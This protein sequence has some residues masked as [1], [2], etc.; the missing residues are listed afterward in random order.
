M[1]DQDEICELEQSFFLRH[2]S[3][4][5][6]LTW[7]VFFMLLGIFHIL[8]TY[9]TRSPQ[10]HRWFSS[11]PLVGYPSGS[12]EKHLG[13]CQLVPDQYIRF[14]LTIRH[15]KLFPTDLRGAIVWFLMADDSTEDY[16]VSDLLRES[17]SRYDSKTISTAAALTA[18]FLRSN[19]AREAAIWKLANPTTVPQLRLLLSLLQRENQDIQDTFMPTIMGRGGVKLTTPTQALKYLSRPDIRFQYLQ[20]QKTFLENSDGRTDP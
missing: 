8:D 17:G 1:P 13:C 6:L 19:D 11:Y 4:A 15:A 2:R 3:V 5:L 10:P 20:E 14:E 18:P 7:V 12:P 9:F 16:D